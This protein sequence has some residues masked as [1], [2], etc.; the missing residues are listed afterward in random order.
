LEISLVRKRIQAAMA[1]SRDRAKRR[2]QKSDEAERAYEIFLEDLAGPLARQ[3]VNALRAEGYSFTVSTPGRGLRL[4]LDQGRDDFI[5]LALSTDVDQ[6]HVVGRIRRTRGSRTLDEESPVKTGAAP[7]DISEAE[8][9][10][11][12]ARALEP[13]LEK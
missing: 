4:S 9:L 8:L 7:Q 1:T 5:E 6:P 3:I 11:F 10:D 12:F 13:W 2:R